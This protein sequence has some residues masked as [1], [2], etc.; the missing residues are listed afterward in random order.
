MAS[1]DDNIIEL[2]IP[3]FCNALYFF[4]LSL[5]GFY[6]SQQVDIFILINNFLKFFNF[7]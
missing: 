1:W 7:I 5:L 3:T 6:P 2:M 4:V